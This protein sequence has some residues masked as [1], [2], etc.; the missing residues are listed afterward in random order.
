M[1][2]DLSYYRKIQGTNGASTAKEAE[3]RMIQNELLRDFEN[4][5]DC[6]DVTVNGTSEK[7]LI[8]KATDPTIKN[9]V[10][11]PTESFD[12]GDIVNWCATDWLIDAIDADTRICT[13]G[14]IRRCNI[15]LKWKDGETIRS[16]PAFCEDATKYSEGV[17]HGKVVELPDF[18]I[19]AKVHLDENSVKL[20]RGKRFLIDAG[21]YLQQIEAGGNH[22][23]AFEV[24][25][26]N[27]ITGNHAGHGCV[28]LTMVECA[29]SEQDNAEMMVADY[30]DPADVYT[31]II[32]N[33]ES[34]LSLAVG[35]TYALTYT[36]TKNGEP[37]DQTSILYASSDT[38]VATISA[39]GEIQ[40][41]STGSSLITISAGKAK[42]AVQIS[43]SSANSSYEIKIEPEDGDYSIA[44]GAEK[45]VMFSIWKDNVEL[46]YT[47]DSEVY[48]GG[49]YAS[50]ISSTN[51]MAVL[52]SSAN[53]NAIG[54]TIILRVQETGNHISKDAIFTI[55]G[56]F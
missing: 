31:L 5:L 32:D 6:E 17:T 29:Y 44:L 15:V 36:A 53:Q 52:R 43:V 50:I 8:T 55:V 34:T 13:R 2:K 27:V 24:T 11:K 3:V 21:N 7:L 48:S 26:R 49:N 23:S 12:L 18:Q 10:A 40:A 30:Y 35:A 22:V 51:N 46:P 9:V 25:R 38:S 28:E 54:N 39:S 33:A 19:K 14:K 56:W 4:S 20:N 47:L 42:K 41:L 16:Y 37:L 1:I 45:T